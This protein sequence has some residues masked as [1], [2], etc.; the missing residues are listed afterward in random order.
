MILENKTA[1]TRK[2]TPTNKIIFIS[3]V[4][5]LWTENGMFCFAGLVCRKWL[6]PVA[7]KKD[8]WALEGEE[9]GGKIYVC[10]IT[11]AGRCKCCVVS[12]CIMCES[13]SDLKKQQSRCNLL[14][15]FFHLLPALLVMN[16]QLC[17]LLPLR[18][19][20]WEL[21]VIFL[22]WK[23]I[24]ESLQNVWKYLCQIVSGM[25]HCHYIHEK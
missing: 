8:V 12:R 5:A 6:Y 22:I 20:L 19:L 16:V 14:P 24:Q 7:D 9:E 2:K 15:W 13:I 1:A 11:D 23:N 4:A 3:A 25:V 17:H 21:L 10:R 18:S